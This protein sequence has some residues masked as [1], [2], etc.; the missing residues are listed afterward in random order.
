MSWEKLLAPATCHTFSAFH[1]VLNKN[2]WQYYLGK[3][4]E[5]K[6]KLATLLSPEALSRALWGCV[7]MLLKTFSFL[8]QSA[9]AI[10]IQRK[11]PTL[12]CEI[13]AVSSWNKTEW[14]FTEG[15]RDREE[16]KEEGWKCWVSGKYR[17]WEWQAAVWQKE[18]QRERKKE[19]GHGCH[20]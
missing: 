12:C 13:T 1:W 5:E 11:V 17:P 18:R 9:N 10:L 4:V 14:C 19:N 7:L 6:T 20:W 8:I 3:D 2:W 16:K 15:E